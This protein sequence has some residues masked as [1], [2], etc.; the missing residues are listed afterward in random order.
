M[1]G[2]AKTFKTSV[3]RS[4]TIKDSRFG[5]RKFPQNLEVPSVFSYSNPGRGQNGEHQV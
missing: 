2:R 1:K 5:L 4:L 3:P